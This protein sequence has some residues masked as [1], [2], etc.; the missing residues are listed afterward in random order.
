MGQVVGL[1]RVVKE[2]FTVRM[3]FGKDLK[4]VRELD[5]AVICGKSVPGQRNSEVL[6][7]GGA[8]CA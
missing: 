3:I 4:D 2:S 8:W 5:M 1:N 6:W 7:L